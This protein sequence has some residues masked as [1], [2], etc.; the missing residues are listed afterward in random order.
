[1]EP[2]GMSIIERYESLE[3]AQAQA[4]YLV[5]HGVGATI[6]TD[7]GTGA[8]GLAVLSADQGRARQL[9]GLAELDPLEA[10]ETD[11]IRANRPWLVPVLLIGLALFV[12]PVVAFFLAFKLSG[13]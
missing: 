3:V 2:T 6:E 13:G 10:T 4:A 5:E 7:G 8:H 12:I 11:L 9:L 1:M